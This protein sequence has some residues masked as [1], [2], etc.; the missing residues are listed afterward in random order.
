MADPNGPFADA[1][2]RMRLA[3]G[4]SRSRGDLADRPSHH[5]GTVAANDNQRHPIAAAE[6]LRALPWMTRD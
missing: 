2:G 6:L 5:S 4:L 3:A 1:S